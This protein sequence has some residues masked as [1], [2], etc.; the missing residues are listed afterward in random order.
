MDKSDDSEEGL[1]A[2]EKELL[3]K[4][5]FVLTTV[6]MTGVR[7]VIVPDSCL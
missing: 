4:G 6:Y 1:N 7:H 3:G 2:Q 5:S